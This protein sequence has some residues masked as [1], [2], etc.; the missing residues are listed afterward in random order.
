MVGTG[1]INSGS[2]QVKRVFL[3][4]NANCFLVTSFF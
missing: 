3:H 2:I 4:K 1:K